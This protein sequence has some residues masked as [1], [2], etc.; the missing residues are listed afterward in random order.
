MNSNL[1]SE[2]SWKTTALKFKVKDNGLQRA[3]AA[4]EGMGEQDYEDR[5]KGIAAVCQMAGTLKKAREV[6]LLPDVFKY[7]AGLTL[8]AEA[9]RAEIAKAKADSAKAEP[10][11]LLPAFGRSL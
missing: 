2:S 8:A 6:I 11:P 9:A 1:I 5:L 3:L 10:G 4:Y 7:L